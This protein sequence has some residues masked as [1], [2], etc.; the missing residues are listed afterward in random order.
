[1]E[2]SLSP[3]GLAA[4]VISSEGIF[5]TDTLHE[6]MIL[7]YTKR[8]DMSAALLTKLTKTQVAFPKDTEKM[9]HHPKALQ[10]LAAFF[11]KQSI[12]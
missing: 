7:D 9:I 12:Q 2:N 1:M 8:F 6:G 10:V 5:C 3:S 4:A 11:F